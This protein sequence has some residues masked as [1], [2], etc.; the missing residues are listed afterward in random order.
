MKCFEKKF[1]REQRISFEYKHHKYLIYKQWT[2]IY[3]ST[4]TTTTNK[5]GDRYANTARKKNVSMNKH[6]T[7]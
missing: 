1:R 3:P 7:E 2:T 4:T 5:R 6:E